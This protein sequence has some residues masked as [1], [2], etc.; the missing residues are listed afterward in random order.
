[1]KRIII[2]C[3]ITY[4]HQAYSQNYNFH[5]NQE[6]N[7]QTKFIQYGSLFENSNRNSPMLAQFNKGQKCVV[8]NYLGQ[9]KYKIKYKYFI[10]Y[11]TSEYLA[12]ND[13]MRLVKKQY[14][15]YVAYIKNESLESNPIKMPNN[16]QKTPLEAPKME[17]IKIQAPI[18]LKAELIEEDS[19][20]T[21]TLIKTVERNIEPE[22]KTDCLYLLNE[23]DVYN[24]TIILRTENYKVSDDLQIELFKKGSKKYVFFNFSG[25]LGCASSYTHNRSFVKIYLENNTQLTISHTWDMDCS[26]FSLKGMLTSSM[27]VKLKE[28][29]IKSIYLQGTKANHLI[30]NITNKKFFINTLQCID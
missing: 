25:D 10:G 30:E 26:D 3:L 19:P 11:V 7:I 23:T 18:E 5:P 28:S 1:M 16:D 24:G 4:F 22:P 12:I 15:A 8:I 13:K 20:L 9:N 29:P 6:L 2:I 14:E 21:D 27:I 17:K